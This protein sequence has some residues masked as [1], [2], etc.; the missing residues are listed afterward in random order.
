MQWQ[1]AG[2]EFT[3]HAAARSWSLN[4][5]APNPG[6]YW[7]DGASSASVLALLGVS[8]TARYDAAAFD[9]TSLVGYERHRGRVQATYCPN[10][11]NGLTIRSTWE[12]TPGLEGIDMEVQLSAKSFQPVRCLEVAIGSRFDEIS[13]PRSEAAVSYRAEPRDERAASLSY[14]GRESL[15]ILR[16]LT[17]LP[18][19]ATCPH[20]L[21]SVIHKLPNG[22]GGI[23]YIEM[24]RPNDCARRIIGRNATLT[25]A[26][27]GPISVRYGLFAHDLEK[28]VVLRGRV[29]CV[30][31]E[32]V[33]GE[34]DVR[35]LHE[36]FLN[37]PP[38]LGA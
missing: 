26:R 10:T 8:T 27:L 1:G 4:L 25:D 12:P 32:R 11:W 21:P 2:P 34:E 16:A 15:P 18:I 5:L 31:L 9:V 19:P 3:I 22:D 17:T 20:I 14:D 36:D 29:R 38:A 35:R 30:W 6:L 23:G 37:E 24:V 7:T 28:G 13:I 33:P